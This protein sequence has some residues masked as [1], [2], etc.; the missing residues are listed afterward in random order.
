[1]ADRGEY[2]SL[3]V[4]FWD[5]AD[6][7]RLS[8]RAYRVL[9]TLRG[10]LGGAG[11]GV[12][13]A[14]VLA[15]RCHC[16]V[17]QL[18]P[19]YQELERV[20]PGE[21]LGWIVREGNVVWVVNAL[22]YEPTLSEGNAK[23]RTHVQRQV[24][25]LGKRRDIVAMFRQHYPAWFAPASLSDGHRKAIARDAKHRT[26]QDSTEPDITVPPPSPARVALLERIADVPGGEAALTAFL[27]GRPATRD[28]VS[29][30]A[31]VNGWLDGLG[32][33]GGK[34]PAPSV[35]VTALADYAA[36]EARD[37]NAKHLRSFVVREMNNPP[38]VGVSGEARTNGRTGKQTSAPKQF[39]YT[40]TEGDVEWPEER[41]K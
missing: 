15:T 13:Y 9:T 34:A 6:V 2:R 38:K 36:G 28:E 26:E 18:D 1:M 7:H 41:A 16:T 37:Y 27:D 4:S 39:E 19:I 8:D 31:L 32:M 23:H 5:N 10:T 24:N 20:K 30:V 33:P 17:E 40:P 35:V 25:A 29:L 11:I 21:E 12:V 3:Y 22:E 14:A